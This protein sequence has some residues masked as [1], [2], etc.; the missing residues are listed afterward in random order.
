ALD[1]VAAD[2]G[3]QRGGGDRSGGDGGSFGLRRGPQG[4]G[5]VV[6]GASGAK[7]SAASSPADDSR[8]AEPLPGV[9]RDER[10]A[11]QAGPG[12]ARRRSW[13]RNGANPSPFPAGREQQSPPPKGPRPAQE[14]DR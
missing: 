7:T 8:P 5:G 4:V 9:A 13:S 14:G 11:R 6:H 10:I 1:A 3:R 2:V 12:V